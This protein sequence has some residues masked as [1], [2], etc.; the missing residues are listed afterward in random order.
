MSIEIVRDMIN[1]EKMVGESSSQTMVNG[2]IV[3]PE[4]NPEFGTILNN[5]G[6]VIIT[7]SEVMNDSILIEGKIMF[8]ILYAAEND[9]TGIYKVSAVSPFNHTL[10]IPGAM[11]NMSCI[12]NTDVE[13]LEYEPMGGRKIKVNSVINIR[14]MV[15]E[16]DTKEFICDIGGDE[17]QILKNPMP[18]DE[19]IGENV[20]QSIVRGNIV[21]PEDKGEVTA[22][23]KSHYHIHK[24]DVVLHEGKAVINACVLARVMYEATG[25]N[26]CY[27]EKD[28]AFTYEIEMP[29][30]RHG[31][32]CDVDYNI[33]E[34]YED[35]KEDENGERKIIEMEMALKIKL[36]AYAS[37]E[38]QVIEDAYSPL[39]RYEFQNETVKCISLFNEAWNIE[40]I[41]EKITIP[42]D[43][44]P[45]G[46]IR[47]M[48]ANPILTDVKIVDDKVVI[49]GVLVC[50]VMYMS[51]ADEPRMAS[52]SEEIPFKAYAE[53]LGARFDM[54]TQV[55]TSI[56][57]ISYEKVSQN[58][59]E[60]KV[61][62]NLG[63][64]VYSRYTIAVVMAVE[65]IDISE[66][67]KN[68][69]SIIIYTVQPGDT[70][71]KIAKRYS[72]TLDKI[73]EINEIED[74]NKIIP[75]IKVLIPKRMSIK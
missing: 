45:I 29:D 27:D 43:K 24:G 52:Y 73:M 41:K 38:I 56:E 21:L 70:L 47:H 59:V 58:E 72:T 35:I 14:G 54:V 7:S 36:K 8:E 26:V 16:K 42:Q 68:M 64:K 17:V 60:I 51:S 71:W 1:Y 62:I 31:V 15:Y 55:R 34:A 2:D 32:K 44:S 69:P 10:Q 48:D 18:I 37:R 40:T 67:I 65:E 28:I 30:L 49:E 22:V 61:I 12:V 33:E 63:A 39:E 57:N 13:N 25:G 9:N 46:Q 20:G 3:L 11:P 74:E 53:V 19:F 50:A 23:L 66:N 5:Y 6:K 4:R 75:G